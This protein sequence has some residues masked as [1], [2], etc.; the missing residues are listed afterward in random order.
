MV[1]ELDQKLIQG[2]IYK[3]DNSYPKLTE[4]YSEVLEKQAH[5]KKT[6][7]G[8]QAPSMNKKLSKAIMNK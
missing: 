8:Y 5:T 2:D 3:T 7:R 4:I 1:H 6:I